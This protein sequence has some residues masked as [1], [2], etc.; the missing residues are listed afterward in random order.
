MSTT[1]AGPRLELAAHAGLMPEPMFLRLLCWERKRAERSNRPFLL[2][3]LD[4]AG[5]FEDRRRAQ[6]LVAALEASKRETDYLGW[7]QTETRL[8]VIYTEIE[9]A[10]PSALQAAVQQRI[11]AAWAPLLTEE[12]LAAVRF[13]FHFFPEP[14]HAEKRPATAAFYPDLEPKRKE[15][16]AARIA[17]RAID[18]VGAALALLFFSP[19]LALAAL[20]IKL[21]SR[22]P[23]LFRQQRLGQFGR[24]FLLFKFRSMH[25]A[26][27]PAIH[28]AYIEQFINGSLPENGSGPQVF[29]IQNDPRVTRAGRWLRKTSFDELPQFWNVLRGEMSLVG[30]RP[31]IPYEA[32]KYRVWHNRRVLE[33]KPGITGLW[34]V[35]G[36]SRTAFEEMVRLDLRYVRNWSLWLDLKILF[37]TPIAV[38][39][40]TGAY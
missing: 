9:G 21:D 40:G 27:D 32:D 36:R 13:S 8:G 20:A 10:A 1:K 38:I 39:F 28:R 25:V 11:A 31:P 12:Q 2:L 19:V 34:Q 5:L 22:G 33:A 35:Y 29:K 24:P 17:K 7:H 14:W 15:Q 23:V 4:G 37:R 30:P 16:R 6:Q 18:I 26:N 3:L